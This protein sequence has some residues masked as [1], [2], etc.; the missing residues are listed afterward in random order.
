MEETPRFLTVVVENK[1][2]TSKERVLSE[3]LVLRCLG[4]RT[5][6]SVLS[7][8]NSK[9]RSHQIKSN[10]LIWL[11][12]AAVSSNQTPNL[13][14]VTVNPGNDRL[15]IYSTNLLTFDFAKEVSG[16]CSFFF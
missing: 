14:E 12:A 5:M 6:T 1:V 13:C 11:L 7:E 9:R 3:N 4:P 16:Q 10:S 2:M 8:F 15:D